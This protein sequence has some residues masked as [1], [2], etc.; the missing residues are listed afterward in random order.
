M[1][2][3]T[4]NNTNGLKG[5]P[6]TVQEIPDGRLVVVK[7]PEN[8]AVLEDVFI[9]DALMRSR[10]ARADF[11]RLLPTMLAEEQDR[12]INLVMARPR[13]RKLLE[14]DQSFTDAVQRKQMRAGVRTRMPKP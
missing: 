9:V 7:D 11:L 5:V 13:L 3:W 12:L 1:S 14:S 6:S 8:P 2:Y 10:V 4:F